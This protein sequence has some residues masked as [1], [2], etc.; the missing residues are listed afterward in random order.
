M[1]KARV[2][3]LRK[4]VKDTAARVNGQRATVPD[5]MK[6]QERQSLEQAATALESSLTPGISEQAGAVQP[7]T[8]LTVSKA[9][10]QAFVQDAT[11]MAQRAAVLNKSLPEQVSKCALSL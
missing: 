3:N 11:H 10:G 7:N 5:V 8:P 2:E 1:L 9:V 6:Q 4:Q